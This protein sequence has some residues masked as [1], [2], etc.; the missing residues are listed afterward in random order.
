MVSPPASASCMRKSQAGPT[1]DWSV[2]LVSMRPLRFWSQR[3]CC[4]D[5]LKC[6]KLGRPPWPF[7]KKSQCRDLCLCLLHTSEFHS[8]HRAKPGWVGSS[9]TCQLSEPWW[10]HEAKLCGPP[11]SRME[12]NLARA[13]SNHHRPW[14]MSLVGLC[15]AHACNPKTKEIETERLVGMHGYFWVE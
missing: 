8:Q 6:H 3:M 1:L 2:F 15:V 14:K 5:G 9:Q 13:L 11:L 4:P 12:R 10:L 7:M